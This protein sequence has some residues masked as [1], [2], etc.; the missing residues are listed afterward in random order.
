MGLPQL[1]MGPLVS[2]PTAGHPPWTFV[3]HLLRC[4]DGRGR[5]LPRAAPAHPGS[6]ARDKAN[7]PCSYSAATFPANAGLQPLIDAQHAIA[8]NKVIVI[9][10]AVILTGSFN[11]TKAA[12]EQ[13]AENL[14]VIKDAYEII[15]LY[16][17]NIATHVAHSK[18]YARQQA[19][20]AGTSSRQAIK[21]TGVVQGNPQSKIYHLPGC[22]D[23]KSLKPSNVVT[24]AT[25]AAAQKAG[26]Q[27]AKNCP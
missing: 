23:Y 10:S 2:R 5:L 3:Q 17:T 21:S 13:N 15:R 6:V 7:Q 8:H 24:F 9:D 12:E 4:H 18:P 1:S 27:K 16:E 19:V 22:P 20:T 14:H 11:F 25:E 26:Y